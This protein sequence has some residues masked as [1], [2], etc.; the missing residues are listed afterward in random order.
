MTNTNTKPLVSELVR[1]GLWEEVE[2][3]YVIHDYTDWQPSA[4]EIEE[5]SRKRAASADARW[6]QHADAGRNATCIAKCNAAKNRIEKNKE[7]EEAEDSLSQVATGKSGGGLAQ[8]QEADQAKS[9]GGLPVKPARPYVAFPACMSADSVTPP[10]EYAFIGRHKLGASLI[11]YASWRWPETFRGPTTR[12]EDLNEFRAAI[13][14]GC[15][16]G[17]TQSKEQRE[18]CYT[19]I[20]EAITDP[21]M[22]GTTWPKKRALFRRIIANTDQRG[23][24]EWRDGSCWSTPTSASAPTAA[25]RQRGSGTSTS[26]TVASPCSQTSLS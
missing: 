19:T 6:T 11:A 3:G 24:R 10:K 8:W 18:H 5:L 23:D 21:R 14:D 2:G 1:V 15:W 13:V 25:L 12:P 26:T 16:P 7:E 17:C 9:G 20:R 4:A 22:E